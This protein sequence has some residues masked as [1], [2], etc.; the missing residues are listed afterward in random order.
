[1]SEL[2]KKKMQLKI[3]LKGRVQPPLLQKVLTTE[4]GFSGDGMPEWTF[5]TNA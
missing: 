1:M 3:S 2:W 4:E 5:F